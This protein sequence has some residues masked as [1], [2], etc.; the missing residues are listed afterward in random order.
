MK[1]K[2][3]KHRKGGKKREEGNM[4]ASVM[5]VK[6]GKQRMGGREL[7]ERSGK[8]GCGEGRGKERK[9]RNGN[10]RREEK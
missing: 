9:Q 10:G 8:H 6:E 3:G 7:A 5:F 4:D 1:R 2:G